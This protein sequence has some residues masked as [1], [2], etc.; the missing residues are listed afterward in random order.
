MPDP[1]GR[2]RTAQH[3]AGCGASLTNNDDVPRDAAPSAY[4]GGFFGVRINSDA[5]LNPPPYDGSFAGVRPI[6]FDGGCIG[7]C[8]VPH[9]DGAVLGVG[10]AP[11]DGGQVT[12]YDGG[13]VGI[14]PVPHD[15]GAI[16]IR[17]NP[18]AALKHDAG[19]GTPY[20]GG[21]AGVWV[22]PDADAKEG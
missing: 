12:P 19:E 2:D 6:P 4:D 11:H 15:G 8:G 21:R 17:I 7:V 3:L 14:G 16:G 20:D 18:D 1:S 5:S 22:T 13:K 10:P 9:Y